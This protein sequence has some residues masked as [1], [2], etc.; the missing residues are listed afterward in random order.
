M[1][2]ANKTLYDSV[3]RSLGRSS[4]DMFNAQEVVTTGKR[5]NRLSDDPV[6]LVAVL[7]LRSSLSNIEQME[8]NISMGRSWLDASESA[9]GQVEDILSSTKELSVQMSNSSVSQS[10]R[11]NSVGIVDGYLKQLISLANSQSGGRYIFGGTDTDATPFALNSDETQVDYYGN[12]TPFSIK[13]GKDSNI[14]VGKDGKD[15]FGENWDDD[16]IFKTLIDLKTDLQSNNISGIQASM[17]RLDSNFNTVNRQISDIGGKVVRLDVREKIISDL[18]LVYTERK[19]EIEDADIAEA[20]IELN[21]RELA[22]NAS[23]ASAAKIMELSLV[24]FL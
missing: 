24:D 23:L 3:I 13:I 15:I 20:I 19:S 9:L 1:R 14:A 4:T 10:E 17:D 18:D 6:G 5:I 12:D 16:N 21:A 8:R 22:Y 7:D 11:A 2:I